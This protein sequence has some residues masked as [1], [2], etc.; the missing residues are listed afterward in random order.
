MQMLDPHFILYF[1]AFDDLGDNSNLRSSFTLELVRKHHHQTQ[2]QKCL[3]L[4]E[5][6]LSS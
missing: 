6:S 2:D 3:E 5:T 4:F 1:T